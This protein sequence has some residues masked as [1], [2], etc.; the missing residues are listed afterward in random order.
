V[1]DVLFSILTSGPFISLLAF[2]IGAAVTHYLDNKL[3]QKGY[4]LLIS[5]MADLIEEENL[6]LPEFLEKL[7]MKLHA[8]DDDTAELEKLIQDEKVKKSI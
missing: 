8:V 3:A 7:I 6:E 4:K 2:V 1:E 5:F